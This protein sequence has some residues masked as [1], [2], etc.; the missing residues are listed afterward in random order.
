M[1]AER[2]TPPLLPEFSVL[3][4]KM[5]LPGGVLEAPPPKMEVE[6]V[7]EP[8]IVGFD[9]AGV[10]GGPLLLS[11]CFSCEIENE[12][13]ISQ[14]KMISE[15]LKHIFYNNILRPGTDISAEIEFFGFCRFGS[16][17]AIP[18]QQ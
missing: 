10:S 11:D 17:A 4:P 3:L 13:S 5:E 16:S 12:L 8:N 2:S 1:D 9:A 14:S 15:Q 7:T 6:G 18:K